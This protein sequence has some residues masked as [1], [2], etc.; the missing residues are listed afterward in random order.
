VILTSP[1]RH[2]VRDP[3]KGDVMKITRKLA[4]TSFG[5]LH[6]RDVG[7]GDVIVLLHVNQQSST[8]YFEMMAELSPHMRVIAPD[9]PSHGGSDRIDFQPTI[10]DYARAVLEIL[11]TEDINNFAL[12]GEAT[13]A[14]VAAEISAMH[15]DRVR[16]IV[17]VNT[18]VNKETPEAMLAP[19][20]SD[21][22]PAD[23]SGFPATRTIDFMLTKDP[24]H[25][26]MNP[27]QSW[28]D[29]VNT[30]QMECGRDRWQAL[31]ALAHYDMI[32]VLAK[33]TQPVLMFTTEFFYFRGA[34]PEIF[35][36]LGDNLIQ[37]IDIKDGRICAA[38]EFAPL[39]GQKTVSFLAD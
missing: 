1:P 18:P 4:E 34:L 6:Y 33:V 30:S 32:A 3:L 29:R 17:L 10:N 7:L 19:F 38:W 20:K 25:S 23:S 26:P 36:T 24:K 31:T 37:A 22:R 8:S 35:E 2:S 13:G 16:K 28:M 14:A 15:P 9:Y 12:L 11:D 39:I 21:F 27:T 5:Q